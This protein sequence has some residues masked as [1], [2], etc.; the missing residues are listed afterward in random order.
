[1]RVMS[2]SVIH[3]ATA[4]LCIH[5][6][7]NSIRG[8]ST[9]LHHLFYSQFAVRYILFL[10]KKLS[11]TIDSSEVGW[12]C[13]LETH[14][15][16]CVS[17]FLFYCGYRFVEPCDL[18]CFVV[19]DGTF[20]VKILVVNTIRLFSACHQFPKSVPAHPVHYP[21][22]REEVVPCAVRFLLKAFLLPFAKDLSSE[23]TIGQ[24]LTTSRQIIIW[25]LFGPS[26][27]NKLC[28]KQV[29]IPVAQVVNLKL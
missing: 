5:G 16:S 22:T 17:M 1:M 27:L 4:D 19:G 7:K 12:W 2:W 21:T 3:V 28:S 20:F 29:F 13:T 15:N 14:M 6:L 25:I 11:V 23:T 9:V 24:I 10:P 18:S 8:D 26:F